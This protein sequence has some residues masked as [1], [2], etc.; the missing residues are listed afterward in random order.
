ML[1]AVN[2]RRSFIELES[3]VDLLIRCLDH[4]KAA[5]QTL[6]LAL[7]GWNL[8]HGV[9]VYVCQRHGAP[10]AFVRLK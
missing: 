8:H 1:L 2:N 10:R 7:D 4:P 5:D 6:L 3:L 9:T